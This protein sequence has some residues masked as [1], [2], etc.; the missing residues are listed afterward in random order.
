MCIRDRQGSDAFAEPVDV[1]WLFS[2]DATTASFVGSVKLR[3]E[4]SGTGDG[5]SYGIEAVVQD[6]SGNS[7][8]A[9]CVVVVPHARGR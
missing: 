3:A 9:S 4:R 2:F 7:T 8:S 6:A 1:T 5:R